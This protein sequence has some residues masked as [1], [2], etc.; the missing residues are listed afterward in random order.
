MV[1]YPETG[2][3]GN[4]IPKRLSI[5]Q[6]CHKHATRTFHGTL[7]KDIWPHCIQPR[8]T[9]P[10]KQKHHVTRCTEQGNN[11]PLCST[12]TREREKKMS[13]KKSSEAAASNARPLE[14]T[15]ASDRTNT[16]YLFHEG[17]NSLIV[18]S[19]LLHIFAF[20]SLESYKWI[21]W[22]ERRKKDFLSRAIGRT[23]S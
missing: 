3:L 19:A 13:D 21:K 14:Y 2:A 1:S 8:N 10:Q 6:N 18:R 12:F 5:K 17:R 7:T 23:M 4:E 11:K 15:R 9:V 20:F 16:V 22:R